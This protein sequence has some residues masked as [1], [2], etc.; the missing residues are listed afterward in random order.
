MNQKLDSQGTSHFSS[1]RAAHSVAY[2]R[3]VHFRSKCEGILIVAAYLSE[4]GEG[5]E[6][7]L[8]PDLTAF[9]LH[10]QPLLLSQTPSEVASLGDHRPLLLTR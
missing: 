3:E 2:N 4:I 8:Q 1:I 5:R 7:E 6:L 10:A 9:Q